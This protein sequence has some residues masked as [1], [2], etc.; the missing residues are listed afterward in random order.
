MRVIRIVNN[1]TILWNQRIT[2]IG[3]EAFEH[4]DSLKEATILAQLKVLKLDA[5]FLDCDMNE[6]EYDEDLEDEEDE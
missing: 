3:D 6:V 2:T 1:K 4:C 5:K